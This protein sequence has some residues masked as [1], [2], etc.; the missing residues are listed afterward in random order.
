MAFEFAF[1]VATRVVLALSPLGSYLQDDSQLSSPLTSYSRRKQPSH[2]KTFDCMTRH[3]DRH[4]HLVQEG[5]YLF[6]HGID[7]YS[8]GSFRH[9]RM[10]LDFVSCHP[11]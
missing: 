9:V 4:H 11:N 1:A 7:P 2:T 5:I 3:H 6:R 8:G 10:W